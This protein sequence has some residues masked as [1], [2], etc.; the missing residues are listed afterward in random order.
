MR[1]RGT[2]LRITGKFKQRNALEQVK[3]FHVYLLVT[4]PLPRAAQ[5]DVQAYAL[6]DREL[7][8]GLAKIQAMY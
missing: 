1:H 8:V 5:H 6:T 7:L 2:P 3:F 4:C